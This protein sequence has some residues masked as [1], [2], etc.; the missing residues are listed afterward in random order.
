MAITQAA[1]DN[2][3]PGEKPEH[4]TEF[5]LKAAIDQFRAGR[6]CKMALWATR[7]GARH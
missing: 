6:R 4:A 2:H 5:S 7:I 1:N 3:Q